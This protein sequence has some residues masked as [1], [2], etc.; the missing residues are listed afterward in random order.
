MHDTVRQMDRQVFA[1]SIWAIFRVLA[2]CSPTYFQGNDWQILSCCLRHTV[3]C[4][5]CFVTK[6]YDVYTVH[7]SRFMCAFLMV[8]HIGMYCKVTLQDVWLT[9]H[10]HTISRAASLA[11]Y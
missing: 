11:L 4:G 8:V 5:Q 9:Q 10:I 6:D 1:W 2:R 3:C 7:A